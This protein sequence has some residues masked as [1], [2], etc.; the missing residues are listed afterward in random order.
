MNFRFEPHVTSDAIARMV[1]KENWD[2]LADVDELRKA[3]RTGDAFSMLTEGDLNFPPT[4][5]YLEGTS[6]YDFS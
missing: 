1:T 5:K 4:Y 2:A 3:Q 6:M